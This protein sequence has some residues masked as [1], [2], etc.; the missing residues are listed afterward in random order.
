MFLSLFAFLSTLIRPGLCLFEELEG[1]MDSWISTFQSAGS[2]S[3]SKADH[4][5]KQVDK[6]HC[7]VFL[8]PFHNPPWHWAPMLQ[9]FSFIFIVLWYLQAELGHWELR[10]ILLSSTDIFTILKLG[11]FLAAYKG[12]CRQDREGTSWCGRQQCRLWK[13]Q[14]SEAGGDPWVTLSKAPVPSKK[15]E[16]PCLVSMGSEA[17]DL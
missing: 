1:L 8:C 10:Y 4:K 14:C 9:S 11:S 12:E 5:W 3:I 7:V 2:H 6:K 13:T 16:F 17:N 15:S